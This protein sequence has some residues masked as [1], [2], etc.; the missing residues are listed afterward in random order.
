MLR[1]VP[2]RQKSLLVLAMPVLLVAALIGTLYRIGESVD[3]AVHWARHSQEVLRMI[4]SVSAGLTTLH[5]ENLQFA[6]LGSG[7]SSFE[8]SARVRAIA[9]DLSTLS[10]MVNDHPRQTK[11]I[12]ELAPRVTQLLTDLA[13]SNSELRDGKL[14]IGA[15][16]S[17]ANDRELGAVALLI[18]D[19]RNEERRLSLERF[20]EVGRFSSQRRRILLFG[21]LAVVGFVAS[22]G[23]SL[24]R[25][26]MRRLFVIQDNV[27]RFARG[28]ELH[29]PIL[30]ADE[31]GQID[32]AFHDMVRIARAQR[33][34]NE[35]FIYSVSHDLR[36]P[37]V[38]LQGFGKEL[39][40]AAKA[41][42]QM[43]GGELDTASRAKM[44]HIT[45]DEMPE[46]LSFIDLAVQR[47][48]RIIDSLLMLSRAGR[49]E[50]Q[51]GT[52]DLD[53]CVHSLVL[54]AK[55]RQA[56]VDAEVVVSKLPMVQGDRN[57]LERVFDNLLDNAIKYAAPGRSARI[58][59]GCLEPTADDV[60]VFVRDNGI[61]IAAA[62]LERAFLPFARFASGPGEG[63][64]L[65]MVRR[66][67]ERH[68][69]RV[70][71]ESQLGT[72]TTVFV[73][74]PLAIPEPRG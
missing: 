66:V 74:L 70:W 19:L 60:T 15:A 43:V 73:R 40:G 42:Q 47:Q 55:G 32:A 4:E 54:L 13:N 31:I 46:A 61:G 44:L 48:A 58:E 30:A 71:I 67:V 23:W 20:D 39:A 68:R 10:L 26:M 29:P 53:A 49:V 1:N 45:G 2:I 63:I 56:M 18:S 65:P 41:L 7:D 16:H 57:A 69:G 28:L 11:A 36:S 50:Y 12:A 17:A 5:G 59:I 64:G 52:V 3:K 14:S 22:F 38:N 51:W 37:L 34:E 9:G 25:S 21:G 72:G 24:L 6:L 27:T 8:V 35:M 62:N 33:S